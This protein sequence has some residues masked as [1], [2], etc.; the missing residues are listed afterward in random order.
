MDTATNK[1]KRKTR[2]STAVKRKYNDKTYTRVNAYLPKEL[3]AKFKTKAQ[4][5]GI[6]VASIIR[7][8]V[9]E[10]VGED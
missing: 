5:E 3:A 7:K 10:Y 2:T 4:N 8:A 6:S 1:P 9:E